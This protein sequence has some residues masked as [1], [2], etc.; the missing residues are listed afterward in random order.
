MKQE[1]IKIVFINNLKRIRE[2]KNITQTK[3]SSISGV[4]VGE[5]ESGKYFPSI[6]TLSKLAS[7]LGVEEWEFLYPGKP[8]VLGLEN[9]AK[10][11]LKEVKQLLKKLDND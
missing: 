2:E 11:I 10:N 5:L 3:L 7:S 8:D 1:D 6:L 4:R 9:S